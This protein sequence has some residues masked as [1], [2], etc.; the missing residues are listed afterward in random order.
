MKISD[1]KE[2]DA[3]DFINDEEDILNYL[4]VVLE[5]NDPSALAQAADTIARSKGMSK[6]FAGK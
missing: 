5:E 3:A 4:N 6:T 1:L 2:F